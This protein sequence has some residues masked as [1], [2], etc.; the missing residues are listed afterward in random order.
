MSYSNSPPR[1]PTDEQVLRDNLRVP[2]LSAE[3]L[4]RIR[5]ATEAEWRRNVAECFDRE[6]HCLCGRACASEWHP[7]PTYRSSPRLY[8]LE[9]VAFRPPRR[10]A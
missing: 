5:R 10:F 4:A 1:D 8:L 7:I 9:S 3:A 2:A 6:G